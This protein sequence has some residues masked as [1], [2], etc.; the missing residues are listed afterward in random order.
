[1]LLIVFSIDDQ[2]SIENIRA[3]WYPEVSHHCPNVPIIL[4]GNKLDLR[5]DRATVERLKRHKLGPIT[6]AQGEKV[7]RKIGAVQLL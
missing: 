1:M 7:V 4:V 6:T 2:N 5:D 3:E